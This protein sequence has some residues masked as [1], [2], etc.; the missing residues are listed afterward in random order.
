MQDDWR[1]KKVTVIGFWIEGEDMAR[2]FADHGAQVTVSTLR[3]VESRRA[4]MAEL[5]SRGVRFFVGA[6]EPEHVAGADLVCVSQ[7]VPLGI[8]ALVAAREAGTP[9]QS[10]T[11][12]FFENYPGPIVGITGSSGKTTTTSLVD[13]IF[14]AANRDHVLGGNIGRGL[15]ALLEDA[16]PDRPAVLEVS[17]TQLQLTQSSPHI[18]CLTNVTPN[19]L[20]QFSWE[21]YV[22][23]KRKIFEFQ[24]PEDT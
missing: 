6:N 20:D 2:Y 10:M 18:A 11:S 12:F 13:A 16:K 21:D 3:G 17:H 14:T 23:L 8:P 5:S 15:L 1:G 19:H 7:G 22:A 9:I 4:A 24:T